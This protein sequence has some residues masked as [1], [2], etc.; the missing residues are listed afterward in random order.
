MFQFQAAEG[1][2]EYKF[3]FPSS[4]STLSFLKYQKLP[5]L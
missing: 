3:N 2:V 1:A 5:V 4:E